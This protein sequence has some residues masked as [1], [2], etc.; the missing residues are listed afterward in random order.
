VNLRTIIYAVPEGFMAVTLEH[1]IIAQGETRQ[2]LYE[3]LARALKVHANVA[4]EKGREPLTYLS[5]A[6]ERFREMWERSD[7]PLTI[8]DVGEVCGIPGLTLE[9]REGV[10][11]GEKS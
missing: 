9:L 5:P 3:E 1:F 4:R 8:L 10:R 11:A 6:P 7:T 2:A